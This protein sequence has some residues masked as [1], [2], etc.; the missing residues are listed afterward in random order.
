MTRATFFLL[1]ILALFTACT[2]GRDVADQDLNVAID[3]ATAETTW[4]D[5]AI[6]SE[7]IIDAYATGGQSAVQAMLPTGASVDFELGTEGQAFPVVI[8]LDFG[9]GSF[10][11]ERFRY[12]KVQ[13]SQSD[14]PTRVNTMRTILPLDYRTNDYAV[15]GSMTLVSTG[16]DAQG[17]PTVEVGVH[18]S[19]IS[20]Q[21]IDIYYEA[22]LEAV[23]LAD[24]QVNSLVTNGGATTYAAY[25]WVGTA[26]GRSRSGVAYQANISTPVYYAIDCRYPR[27]GVVVV[28]QQGRGD[29]YVDYDRA[30]TACDGRIGV[31]AGTRELL[32]TLP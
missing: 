30:N 24:Q 10:F 21:D 16:V 1:S 29:Q 23:R 31:G 22:Q 9:E 8:T 4:L 7:Y 2:D 3:Y 20:T 26:T 19:T 14:V 17:K 12:G 28:S 13:I 25:E 18:E 27:S 32:Y 5:M 11:N 6:S 15:T